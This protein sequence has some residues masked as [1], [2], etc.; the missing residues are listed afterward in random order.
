MQDF[1]DMS[2]IKYK[3]L[4]VLLEKYL[5]DSYFLQNSFYWEAIGGYKYILFDGYI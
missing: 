3:I 4:Q 2:N 5:Q 1:Q